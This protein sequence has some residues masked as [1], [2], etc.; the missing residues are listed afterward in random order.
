MFP[1][2]DTFRPERYLDV[3]QAT[4]PPNAPFFFGFGRRICPGMHI[5]MNSLFTVISRILWA[6]DINPPKDSNGRPIIPST[7]DFIGGLVIRPRPFTFSLELRRPEEDAK[8]VI[9][10]E[11]KQAEDEAMA[12]K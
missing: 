8:D 3:E 9:K 10:M 1:C 5:A 12:W 2:P 7:D 4:S 11:S 6:F